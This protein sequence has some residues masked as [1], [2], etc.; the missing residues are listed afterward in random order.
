MKIRPELFLIFLFFSCIYDP[1]PKGKELII[2]NQTDKPIMVLDS[3]TGNYYRLYDTAKVNGKRYISR[4]ADYLTE[5]GMFVNFI[6]E[7]EF[8]SMGRKNLDK[9]TLY[10]VNQDELQNSPKSTLTNNSF[11]SIDISIDILK[12]FELNHLFITNDSLFLKH[13]YDYYT[14]WKQ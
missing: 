3:L 7:D 5:Y 14:N 6:S 1:P 11:R 4:R 12:E 2:H 10:V 13:E 9:I 8:N